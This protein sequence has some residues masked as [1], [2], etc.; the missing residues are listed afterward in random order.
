M[1]NKPTHSRASTQRHRHK[2]KWEASNHCD[3]KNPI[4]TWAL[5]EKAAKRL[6][7][8]EGEEH[9]EPYKCRVC[10]AYHVGR[11][12]RKKGRPDAADDS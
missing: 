3:P 4:G 10:P 2:R 5:A 11:A 8:H 7:R 6:N 12:H 9:V 1:A